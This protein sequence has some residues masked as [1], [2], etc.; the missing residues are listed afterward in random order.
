MT[1]TTKR[2]RPTKYGTSA[3]EPHSIRIPEDKTQEIQVWA[4]IMGYSFADAVNQII[5]EWSE[6]NE[7][8]DKA[9]RDHKIA[10]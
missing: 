7:K 4:E 9:R 5:R 10:G 1:G 3:T 6:R 8:L 2:G